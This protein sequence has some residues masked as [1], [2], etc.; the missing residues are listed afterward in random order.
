[1]T[2]IHRILVIIRNV[3]DISCIK[4][5]NTFFMFNNF[6]GNS[7]AGQTTNENITRCMSCVCWMKQGYHHLPFTHTHTHTHTHS[8][9]Y[10]LLFPNN[11][12]CTNAPQFS[13]T[14][15]LPVL[16]LIVITIKIQHSKLCNFIQIQYYHF[17]ISYNNHKNTALRS[18]PVSRPLM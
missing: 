1:M 13:V 11:N 5:Q 8:M 3:S 2:I 16:L 15:A 9:W 18:K 6:S 4:N 7:R 14:R 10:L 12:V 17:I